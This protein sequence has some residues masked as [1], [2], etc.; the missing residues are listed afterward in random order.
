MTTEHISF[1]CQVQSTN[2]SAALG[3]R[4][5]L[6][7]VPIYENAHVTETVNYNTTYPMLTASMS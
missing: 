3:L 4:I 1:T 2:N 7:Q 5:M 6:D